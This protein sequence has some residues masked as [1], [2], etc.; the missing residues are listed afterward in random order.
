[1]YNVMVGVGDVPGDPAPFL[2]GTA[3]LPGQKSTRMPSNKCIAEKI[4]TENQINA[5]LTER[6]RWQNCGCC[7][8]FRL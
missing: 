1:M 5:A 8:D 2:D 6:V 7:S 3:N 4:F